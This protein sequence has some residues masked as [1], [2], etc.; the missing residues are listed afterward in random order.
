M[1]SKLF[2]LEKAPFLTIALF[3]YSLTFKYFED[4][5]KAIAKTA[6]ADHAFTLFIIFL[7]IGSIALGLYI[8]FIIAEKNVTR[9]LEKTKGGQGESTEA[10]G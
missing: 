4:L 6:E 8:G 1:K 7:F 9:N 3:S 5:R 10:T 2:T